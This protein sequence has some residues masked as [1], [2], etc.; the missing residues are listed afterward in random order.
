[1]AACTYLNIPPAT[2]LCSRPRKHSSISSFSFFSFSLSPR[3]FSPFLT[4]F[5]FFLYLLFFSPSFYLSLCL[6]P[7]ILPLYTLFTAS[8]PL[9]TLSQ[10]FSPFTLS[11]SSRSPIFL[12]FHAYPILSLFLFPSL[13]SL[14]QP[15]PSLCTEMECSKRRGKEGNWQQN[16]FTWRHSSRPLPFHVPSLCL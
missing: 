15:L 13:S 9:L 11:I 8:L 16:S 7:S 14:S 12:S 2:A 3:S 10:P 1:M 4:F 5:S 6:L